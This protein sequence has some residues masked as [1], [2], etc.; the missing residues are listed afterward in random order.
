TY[1]CQMNK[2]DSER[3][4]GML[5][6]FGF[7]EVDAPEAA[8]V[9]LMNS[10]SVR[11]TAEDRVFG[12]MTRFRTL[13][14]QNPELVIGVTGCLPG[15]DR[16]GKLRAKLPEADLFF[17]IADLPKLP[18]W[19]AEFFPELV[20]TEELADDYLK[21]P[22]L[23]QGIRQALV[24]IQTGCRK[25]CT[26]CV[27]PFSRG[28]VRNR[29][30]ADILSEIRILAKGGCLEVTLLGQT[31][32]SYRAPDAER[33]SAN[34]PFHDHFAA[35][36][37]E[38]NQIPGLRRLHFTAPHPLHMTD[39]VIEAMAW[40]CHVNFIHLPVQ[41][42]DNE[43]LRRMNR[44]YTVEQYL[45]TVGKLRRR[46][47][48]LAVGTDIIVGFCGET[49]EQFARTVELYRQVEFD[50]SYTAMYSPRSGT[51]AH[52]A[53]ADTVSREEKR[54]RWRALQE[55]MEEIVLR[56][57]QRYVG[58]TVEVLVER[59]EPPGICFGNSR[60]MKMVQFSGAEDLVGQIVSVKVVKAREWIL[61]GERDGGAKAS[62]G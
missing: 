8:D 31:V 27:V 33:F 61:E 29:P 51:A 6:S 32:N 13:K 48:Y 37:W 47:P 9:V 44:R 62:Y 46:L 7:R 52:R 56:K 14:E 18:G 49:E 59:F 2:N 57:N 50:I 3:I 42:G 40:P 28:L 26:Y 30:L 20:N 43:V 25:F 5:A 16:D 53:L 38:V 58:K 21:A 41:S 45:E 1:G 39:E 10:C 15:R 36:L 35:L 23:R 54:R 17:P 12:L 22:P 4:A 55:V 19:L 24:T 34:N 60:E 11:Q